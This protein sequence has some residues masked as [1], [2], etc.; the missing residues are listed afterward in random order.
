MTETPDNAQNHVVAVFDE[1]EQVSKTLDALRGAGIPNDAISVVGREQMDPET[2]SDEDAFEASSSAGKG[3]LK[4][5][6]VGGAAGGLAGLIGGALA[7][8]IPGVGPAIGVGLLV[9]AVSGAAAGTV[10]G[11]LWSGFE[12]MWDMGYR[13]LVSGGGILVAVHT[14]DPAIADTA[15]RVLSD[16]GPTRIDHLDAHGEL[17]RRA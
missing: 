9:T 6:A 12:R 3:V 5:S 14:D 13:D 1:A 11:A 4:G 8:A 10:A 2:D 16:L 17:V 7:F 15:K